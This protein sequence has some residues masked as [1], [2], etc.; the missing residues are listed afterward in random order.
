MEDL[1]DPELLRLKPK[2]NRN[3]CMYGWLRGSYMKSNAPVHVPGVGDFRI[4]DVNF[5]SDPC[6]LPGNEMK[7]SLNEKEKILYS[8][9]SGVNGILFDKDAVYINL[10][11]SHSHKK[12]EVDNEVIDSLF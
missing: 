9:F 4:K 6:P 8:P 1:T 11:G 3:V 2:C 5:L 10:G 7:R 12:H